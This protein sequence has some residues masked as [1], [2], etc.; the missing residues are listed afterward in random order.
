[1]TTLRCPALKLLLASA[2]LFGAVS[3]VAEQIPV[4]YP[5]GV[6]HGFLLLRS[7]EGKVIASGDLDQTVQG[8]V[9][10]TKLEF[11]FLDGSVHEETSV[12]SQRRVFRVLTYRLLEKG[13]S[14]KS[15]IEVWID[16]EKSEVKVRDMKDGK[17]KIA[18]QRMTI[19]ADLANGIV[20]TIIK[21]FGNDAPHTL[22]M[23]AATPK[24]RMVK[25]VITPEGEDSFS[26]GAN[27]YKAR[28]YVG[29]IKIGGIAGVVAPLVGKQPPDTHFWVLR[30]AAPTFLKSL[31][32]LGADTPVWQIELAS[33]RW[34]D[35]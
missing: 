8:T 29:K 6:T 34:A 22:A 21:D 12:F 19:P 32:P 20:S 3:S 24:P 35:K 31:G 1:L 17:D 28:R 14:F 13:P 15:P 7:E 26:V 2:I 10:T 5:E 23:L 16:S 4:K 27:S 11:H 25:M 30:G 9:V 18:A 33:P